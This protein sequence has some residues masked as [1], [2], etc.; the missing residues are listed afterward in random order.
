VKKVIK[1]DSIVLSGTTLKIN[2]NNKQG[3]FVEILDRVKSQ[4]DAM[5][6][7][8]CQ[9]LVIRLDLRMY[10]YHENNEMLSR[11]VRKVRKKLKAKYSFARVGFVWVR[12][13]E[14]AKHQ[15]YHFAL[16]LDANKVRYPVKILT[17]CSTIWEN[18]GQSPYTPKNCYYHIK[19]GDSAAY[20]S[21]FKR[22]SYLAK[23][24]GKGYKGKTANDYGNS[25]IKPKPPELTSQVQEQQ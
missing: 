24:R 5:L 21:A 23:E 10:E 3:C 12:E 2:G 16:L 1:S 8:H 14:K 9:I 13:M 6:S 11:F 7:H 19:R 17:I 25:R 4:M 20:Q 15:H 18:W 22:L